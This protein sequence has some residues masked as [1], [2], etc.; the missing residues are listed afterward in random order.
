M[1]KFHITGYESTTKDS[2]YRSSTPVDVTVF[3]DTITEAIEK[4]EAVI[5]SY[6]SIES[7]NIVVT[8]VPKHMKR[9]RGYEI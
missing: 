6:I 5:C 4:A 2:L 7:R 1:Y 9:R 3:A 8:E